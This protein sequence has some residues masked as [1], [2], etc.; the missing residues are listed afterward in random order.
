MIERDHME[1]YIPFLFIDYF[2][3][4]FKQ[5]EYFPV[6]RLGNSSMITVKTT[7]EP[8]VVKENIVQPS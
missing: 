1:I 2:S 4:S 7:Q 5:V 8:V 6:R 3:F